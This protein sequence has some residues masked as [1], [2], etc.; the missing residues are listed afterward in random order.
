[1][2]PL[3]YFNILAA[4]SACGCVVVVRL[5]SGISALLGAL[6]H[7]IESTII[8]FL[9][10][11]LSGR[12]D[13]CMFRRV[14]TFFPVIDRVGRPRWVHRLFSA[15]EFFVANVA[16][17]QSVGRRGQRRCQ[18]IHMIAAI[19]VVAEEQLIVVV[20]GAANRAI[21]AFDALPAVSFHGDYHVR[22]ELQAR[23]MAGST[24]VG[25]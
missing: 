4:Q 20:G 6:T 10:F 2:R 23:R 9:H 11:L 15:V 7:P 21:L 3:I 25:A 19:A 5:R 16:A 12:I 14:N 8:P 18:A 17:P 24:T 22:C 13:E 1:M